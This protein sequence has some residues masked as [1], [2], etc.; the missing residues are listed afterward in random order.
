MEVALRRLA[1]VRGEGPELWLAAVTHL[2]T[3]EYYRELQRFLE[4]RSVVLFEAVRADDDGQPAPREGYSLQGEL[5]GALGLAFQLDEIKYDRPHFHNSD[6]DLEQITRLF[7][8][9]PGSGPAPQGEAK[10]ATGG[11]EFSALM[12]AMTGEG[13]M[14]GLARLSVAVLRASP[15]LQAATK[16]AMIEVLGDLP[17]DLTGIPG[18]PEGMQR[19]LRVLIEERNLAVVRDV[20]AAFARDPL[21]KSVAVFYG[22]GH[23]ADLESRLAEALGYQPVEDRWLEAFR[24]DP[25]AMGVSEFEVAFTTRL[26]RAQLKGIERSPR[27]PAQETNAPAP[28]RIET[29]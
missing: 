6:L 16:V 9:R 19:L 25:Q 23:M 14:G 8:G 21:P 22:A 7:A 26:V 24:V 20:R 29:P 5:A 2:G 27:A 1:P 11:I 10:A 18:L 13:L 4:D 3:A 28:A 12:Q 17:N 15:R